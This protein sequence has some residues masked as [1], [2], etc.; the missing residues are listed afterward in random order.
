MFEQT[1]LG[2][3]LKYEVPVVFQI[4]MNQSNKSLFYEPN[5]NLVRA[6]CSASKDTSLN[7]AKF[8]RYLAEYEQKGLYCNVGQRMTPVKMAYYERIR[9][10]KLKMYIESNKEQILAT[11][12][13]IKERV[14]RL[15]KSRFYLNSKVF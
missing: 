10:A 2:F 3:F 7:K 15:N 9:R 4:I 8:Q 1:K 11:R 13:A 12:F 6:I 5:F 14:L